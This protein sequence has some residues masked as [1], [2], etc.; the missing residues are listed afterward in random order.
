MLKGVYNA[1]G[2]VYGALHAA[3]RHVP[4]RAMYHVPATSNNR[5]SPIHS[6]TSNMRLCFRL[7]LKCL[8]YYC[9]MGG[10][11]CSR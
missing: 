6:T 10:A 2:A 11:P 8:Q 7:K 3:D 4:E 5:H 1:N 9:G